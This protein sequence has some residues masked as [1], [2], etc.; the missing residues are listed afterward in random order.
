MPKIAIVLLVVLGLGI[1]Q[2]IVDKTMGIDLSGV[3]LPKRIVHDLTLKLAG[4][5]IATAIWFG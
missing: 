2:V 5:G 3:S 4:G 1:V